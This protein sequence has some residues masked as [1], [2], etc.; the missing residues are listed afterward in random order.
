MQIKHIYINLIFKINLISEFYKKYM[1]F[2]SSK[3]L[4]NN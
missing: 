2:H 4:F 3:K 1:Y